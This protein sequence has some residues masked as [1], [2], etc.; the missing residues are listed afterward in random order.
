MGTGYKAIIFS[1]VL[2]VISHSIDSEAKKKRRTSG[3][4]SQPASTDTRGWKQE[5][6]DIF[7]DCYRAHGSRLD[8]VYSRLS[9]K[10]E[11]C[12]SG[13]N[14]AAFWLSIFIPLAG[15][16]SSYRPTLQS[17]GNP[18]IGLF[19]MEPK[20]MRRNGCKG[21]NPRNL[22]QNICCAVRIAANVSRRTSKIS[23]TGRTGVMGS[24]WQPMMQEHSWKRSR[25]KSASRKLCTSKH[26]KLSPAFSYQ[27]F[28]SIASNNEQ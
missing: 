12:S 18:N 4:R 3:S 13:T 20:D 6:S 16:E 15:E 27:N 2:L 11:Y 22:K 10:A 28:R 25:I 5:W 19:Q 9:D 24:F 17:R 23:G 14:P 21:S 26:A 8:T 7:M 1:V